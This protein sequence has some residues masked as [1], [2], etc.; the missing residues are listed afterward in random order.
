MLKIGR[1]NSVLVCSCPKIESNRIKP[2]SYSFMQK[3][4][5]VKIWTFGNKLEGLFVDV[6]TWEPW[7][8]GVKKVPGFQTIYVYWKLENIFPSPVFGQSRVKVK[9]WWVFSSLKNIQRSCTDF[10]AVVTL[11]KDLQ[12]GSKPVDPSHIMHWSLFCSL[13]NI[14]EPECVT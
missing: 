10:I 3:K 12:P 6:L 1:E 11:T 8:H 14:S 7:E 5:Y 4:L 2:K 9:V 13:L